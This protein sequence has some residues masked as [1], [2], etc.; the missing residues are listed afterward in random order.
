MTLLTPD[1]TDGNTFKGVSQSFNNRIV[2]WGTSPPASGQR[3]DKMLWFQPSAL[4]QP[5]EWDSGGSLWRSAPQM[6]NLAASN[7][8]IGS[9][10][11]FRVDMP[12]NDK[13]SGYV[14]I[15]EV[16]LTC[17]PRSAAFSSSNY[18]Q[19]LFRWYNTSGTATTLITWNTTNCTTNNALYSNNNT[20]YNYL[21]NPA[22]FSLEGTKVGSPTG[23]PLVG[24]TFIM[25]FVSFA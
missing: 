1:G 13:G 10:T 14:W 25:K 19:I 18:W 21:N 20:V 2:A 11:A 6:F 12:V 7:T 23:V 8:F 22:T 16:W 17:S 5:W 4:P 3:T 15:D 9:N 24:C